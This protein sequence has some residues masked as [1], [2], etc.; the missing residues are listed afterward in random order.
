MAVPYFHFYKLEPMKYVKPTI[1]LT[2]IFFSPLQSQAFWF[3]YSISGS[4][5]PWHCI[6]VNSTIISFPTKVEEKK[7]PATGCHLRKVYSTLNSWLYAE[8]L[9]KPHC[10]KRGG[11]CKQCQGDTG[12][13]CGP[14]QHINQCSLSCLVRIAIEAPSE[15]DLNEIIDVWQ[16]IS[17]KI[18]V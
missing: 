7:P 17:R 15:S 9:Q 10:K 14:P 8:I 11:S 3:D 16:R 18:N 13:Q 2:W 4:I 5:I 6:V 12:G 1:R